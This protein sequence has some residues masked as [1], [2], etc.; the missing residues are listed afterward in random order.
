[1]QNYAIALF[2]FNRP[3]LL[4]QTLAAL[5]TNKLA[6]AASLTIFCDGPAMK[7]MSSAHKLCA[8]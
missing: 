5:S 4:Q 6:D 7:K 8:R 2:A 1:M 3:D